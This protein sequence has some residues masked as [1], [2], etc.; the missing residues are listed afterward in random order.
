[1]SGATDYFFIKCI[2]FGSSDKGFTL[3]QGI[4]FRRTVLLGLAV[5]NLLVS[6]AALRAVTLQAA[7]FD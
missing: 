4:Y 1:M 3:L 5:R 2:W 6:P 7:V